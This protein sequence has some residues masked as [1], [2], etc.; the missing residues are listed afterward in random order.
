[1]IYYG[2]DPMTLN[3]GESHVFEGLRS[4]GTT[5]ADGQL[6]YEPND[7]AVILDQEYYQD[8]Y[9][10]IGENFVEDGSWVRLRYVTLTY[11]LPSKW[12]G[13]KI[14]MAQFNITGRN[15]IVLTNYS[16]VDPEINTIGAAVTGTGSIGIDNLGTPSTKGFDFSLKFTF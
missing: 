13:N 9:S 10:T 8:I 5:D 6:I 1:M 15:L 16:G 3:R 14:S 7:R 11:N 4:T 12:F 2:L